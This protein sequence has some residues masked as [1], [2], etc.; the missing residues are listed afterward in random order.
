MSTCLSAYTRPVSFFVAL[1]TT[2]N[3]PF[4]M[5]TSF[6]KS[7]RE[8]RFTP[9][10]CSPGMACAFGFAAAGPPPLRAEPLMVSDVAPVGEDSDRASSR[11][12]APRDAIC[13][14]T[15]GA[16][17]SDA[18]LILSGSSR[19]KSVCSRLD[20]TKVSLAS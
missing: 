16:N 20:S 13:E 7:A 15:A 5:V 14:S 10:P 1:Y 17:G 3:E 9:P 11:A 8:W 2:P 19:F 12:G 4:A 18:A 6:S